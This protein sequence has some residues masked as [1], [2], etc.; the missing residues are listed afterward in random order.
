MYPSTYETSEDHSRQQLSIP[1]P[2]SGMYDASQLSAAYSQQLTQSPYHP[3]TGAPTADTSAS[4]SATMV[5]YFPKQALIASSSFQPSTSDWSSHPPRVAS[6]QAGP[7]QSRSTSTSTVGTGHGPKTSRQQFTA[8]GACRHRR[9]KCDLKDRQEEAER[10]AALELQNGTVG[11]V[12]GQ[13]KRR[14]VSCTNCLERKMNCIDEYAPLKAQKQLRRGKRIS[15]IENIYGKS[16]TNAAMASSEDSEATSSREALRDIATLPELTLEFF[17]SPFFRRFQVQRPVIDPDDFV[18]RYLRPTNPTA[19]AMGPEGAILCHVLYAWAVSYGVDE[20]GNCDVPENGGAPLL[21][22]SLLHPSDAEASRE[23]DRQGRRAKMRYVVEII[24]REID[25][26]GILRRPSWDG[27]R[28]LLLLLPLTEGISTS[29]ERLTMYESAVSQVHALCSFNAL[30]Y[31]GQPSAASSANGGTDSREGRD[32]LLVRVRVYWYA[33]VHE[34]ITTGLKGGR[35]HLD[36]DDLETIQDS[37]NHRSLMVKSPEMKSSIKFATAPIQLAMACRLINK[38]LT[39]Q[40]AR[41]KADVN[42]AL[43]KEAWEALEKC[44]EEFDALR[45]E[46]PGSYTSAD[47]VIRFSDGWKIFLFEAQNVI[48]TSLEKRL[49]GIVSQTGAYISDP[50]STNGEVTNLRHLLDISKS[51]CEV[52]TRQT[53]DIIKRHVGTSFFEWDAS[54]VRDGTYYT[55]MLLAKMRDTD[56]DIVICLRALNELR[57]AHAKSFERSAD[58]RREWQQTRSSSSS[59]HIFPWDPLATGPTSA[60]S[61]PNHSPHFSPPSTEYNYQLQPSHSHSLVQVIK[62]DPSPGPGEENVWN[63]RYEFVRQDSTSLS[64]S[65]SGSTT[66][67]MSVPPAPMGQEMEEMGYVQHNFDIYNPEGYYF[68]QG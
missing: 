34:G 1:I 5:D 14:K 31:D 40:V 7:S 59:E 18:Q 41:R 54:L 32:Y 21:N 56:E 6:L 4:T 57:W 64:A 63:D 20:R 19:A 24:L 50:D 27:V 60:H 43:V 46:P 45:H 11:P 13:G 42:A 35:L 3:P 61:L 25:D 62:S 29:V 16:A 30:G 52:Q 58:L 17:E 15:E 9:V 65:G 38:A 51:K 53:M 26:A 2:P 47:E 12:R 23:A 49:E 10:Q 44:W 67:Y 33:F 39:G 8:C 28:V 68:H 48:R 55:A 36:G 66:G 22:V 37:I